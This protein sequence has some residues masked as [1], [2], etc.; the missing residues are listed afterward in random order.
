MSGGGL[1]QCFLP[2]RARIGTMYNVTKCELGT[3]C[4]L[5]SRDVTH[6]PTC[7]TATAWRD[8]TWHYVIFCMPLLV[9]LLHHDLMWCDITWHDMFPYMLHC[10]IVISYMSYVPLNASLLQHDMMWRNIA[11]C[12]AVPYIMHCSTVM[13]IVPLHATLLHHDIMWHDIMWH[14]IMWHDAFSYMLHY[15]IVT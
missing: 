1:R 6:S 7:S 15:S 4:Y 10:S 14:D 13:S 3:W 2:R 11:G 9:T 8:V 5:T 12:D